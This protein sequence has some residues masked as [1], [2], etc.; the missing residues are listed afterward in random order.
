MKPIKVV[1]HKGLYVEIYPTYYKL[2]LDGK[3]LGMLTKEEFAEIIADFN[4]GD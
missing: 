1:D 2:W 3:F 4:E